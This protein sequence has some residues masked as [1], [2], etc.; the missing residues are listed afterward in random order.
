MAVASPPNGRVSMASPT[1]AS[2][3]PVQAGPPTRRPC[4]NLAMS[5][6]TT[7]ASPVM[8]PER[9]GVVKRSP[10]VWSV[11]PANMAR[12]SSPPSR[13]RPGVGRCRRT[14]QSAPRT[15]VARPKR[16]ERKTPGLV[17]AS[18]TRFTSVKVVPQTSVSRSSARS[19]TAAGL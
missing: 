19:A 6:T 12:P 8:N 4:R 11:N 9:A 15:A 1:T 18:R 16:S 7:T 14:S 10:K 3:T 13:K 17:P 5:G 2:V